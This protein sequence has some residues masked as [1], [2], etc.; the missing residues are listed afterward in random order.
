MGPAALQDCLR[1]LFSR[2]VERESGQ[3]KAPKLAYA[4][5]QAI[6]RR[7]EY[8]PFLY[9][10]QYQPCTVKEDYD[11]EKMITDPDNRVNTRTCIMIGN[12]YMVANRESHQQR[13]ACLILISD[14]IQSHPYC[15]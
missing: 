2:L 5:R 3:S 11:D 14:M 6:M 1:K 4:F 12:F 9:G 15:T 13:H 8:F 7:E 10:D